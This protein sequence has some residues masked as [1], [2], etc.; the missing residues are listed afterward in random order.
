MHRRN[1]GMF[2]QRQTS[3]KEVEAKRLD[4]PIPLE[5]TTGY[6]SIWELIT[7]LFSLEVAAI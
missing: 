5:E 6:P 4:S 2:P 1:R 3:I 7:I